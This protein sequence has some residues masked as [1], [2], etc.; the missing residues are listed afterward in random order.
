MA[1]T[2]DDVLEKFGSLCTPLG[3]ISGKSMFGGFGVFCDGLMFALIT[4]QGELYLKSDDEN[5]P[6]HERAGLEKHGRMPYYRAPEDALT[7]WRVLKPW[8]SAA[9]LAARRAPAKPETKRK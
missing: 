4:G 5:R 8:A 3:T 6:K 2:K 1:E 7:G 9:Y